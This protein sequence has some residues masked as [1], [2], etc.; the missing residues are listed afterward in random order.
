VHPQSAGELNAGRYSVGDP[1]RGLE[2][3]ISAVNPAGVTCD[4]SQ[5]GR[6]AG[7]FQIYSLSN[8]MDSPAIVYVSRADR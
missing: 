1:R 6:S 7:Y 3:R 5:G 8:F 2:V 4:Q